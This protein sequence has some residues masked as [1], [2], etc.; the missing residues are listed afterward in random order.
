MA[1]WRSAA[2]GDVVDCLDRI[3][4][5]VKS[6]DRISGPYPYYGASGVIDHVDGYLFDGTYAL[7]A[8]DGENL[9]TRK[10]PI[11]FLGRGHLWVNNHAHILG[12]TEDADVRFIRYRLE[13]SDVSGYLTGSTRPK[14][15]QGALLSMRFDWP[16][17]EE[18]RM[19]AD[20]VES[21]DDKIDE[22]QQL[23]LTLRH[24]ALGLFHSSVADDPCTAV[25]DEFVLS[26]SRG[27]APKYVDDEM[28]VLVLNQKC[29]RNG[30]ASL[31]QARWMT[32]VEPPVAKVAH[33]GDILVNSTGV[34]TLGRVGRWID[35]NSICVDGHVTV[36]RPDPTKCAPAILGYALLDSEEELAALGEGSTGQT[37]LGRGRLARFSVAMPRRPTEHLADS[38]DAL[39][40][41]AEG[42]SRESSAL[43]ALRDTVLPELL[44]GA[45][46]LPEPT[47]DAP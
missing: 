16:E 32:E 15:T 46:R 22:N 7:I 42:L 19:I 37:E 45:I 6:A 12:G 33:Q 23:R 18:Q 10:T 4:R 29:I 3:R 1:E 11:A 20:L 25:L 17:I 30:W 36:I 38:L 44:S 27:I 2:V 5:P 8:E 28:G 39:D 43:I 13:R 47:Q 41:L 40:R 26:I 21:L 31:E 24:L 35:E 9:R 34:G 14:L